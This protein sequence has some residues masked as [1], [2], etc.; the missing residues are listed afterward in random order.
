MKY[1][2]FTLNEKVTVGIILF[3]LIVIFVIAGY[4]VY[5]LIAGMS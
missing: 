3:V 5:L 4:G 1:E 2:K